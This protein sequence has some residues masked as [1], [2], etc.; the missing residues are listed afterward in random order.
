MF[1]VY[2]H[3]YIS[4][5][6]TQ[7]RLLNENGGIPKAGAAIETKVIISPFTLREFFFQKNCKISNLA[8]NPS[9][10][11]SVLVDGR[12]LPNGKFR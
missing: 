8:R 6:L 12:R 2:T 7:K 11:T 3:H 1:C 9:S 4:R 10:L 5:G